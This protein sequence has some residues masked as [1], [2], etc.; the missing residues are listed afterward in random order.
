MIFYINVAIY[1]LLLN[2][3]SVYTSYPSLLKEICSY[4]IKDDILL[5]AIAAFAFSTASADFTKEIKEMNLQ[6][7]RFIPIRLKFCF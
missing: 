3:Y 6:K 5:S 4:S 1:Y 2:K 7:L